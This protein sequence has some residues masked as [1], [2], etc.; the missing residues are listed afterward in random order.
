M[1]PSRQ[2]PEGRRS[3]PQGPGEILNGQVLLEEEK[4]QRVSFL[5]RVSSDESQRCSTEIDDEQKEAMW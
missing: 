1:L 4:D 2:S 5:L 3:H